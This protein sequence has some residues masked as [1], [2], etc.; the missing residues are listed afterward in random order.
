MFTGKLALRYI[1]TQKRHSALTVCS[2]ALAIAILTVIFTA[3]TTYMGCMYEVTYKKTPYHYTFSYYIV[4]GDTQKSEKID[5]FI[6]KFKEYGT[7]EKEENEVIVSFE[8]RISGSVYC[9]FE[10]TFP[11][12][13]GKTAVETIRDLLGEVGLQVKMHGASISDDDVGYI[14]SSSL[15]NYRPVDDNDRVQ[16]VLWIILLYV[17]II[18]IILVLR[19][20]ID[21]AFEISSKERERQFGV[22]QSV[23]ATPMQIVRIITFEGLIL[24]VAGLPLGILAGI[25]IAFAVFKIIVNECIIGVFFTA[26]QASELIKLHVNPLLTFLAAATGILWVLLSAYGVGMRVIKKTPI[27][28]MSARSNA[29]K[30]VKKR[31]LFGKIFGWTGTLAARNNRRQPKRFIVSVLSLTV[32]ITL[33]ASVT[34]IV[35]KFENS[36]T[37]PLEEQA[38]LAEFNFGV[39]YYYKPTSGNTAYEDVCKRFEES[40]M[41]KEPLAYIANTDYNIISQNPGEDPSRYIILFLNK[42]LYMKLFNNNPP[43]SYEELS[44]NRSYIMKDCYYLNAE[45]GKITYTRQD[46]L[47]TLDKENILPEYVDKFQKGDPSLYFGDSYGEST[48]EPEVAED[49][50]EDSED[51]MYSYIYRGTTEKTL[52]IAATYT[53]G[54]NDSFRHS[55]G[56]LVLPGFDM[57][58]FISTVDAYYSGEYQYDYD[59]VMFGGNMLSDTFVDL[60]DPTNYDKAEDFLNKNGDLFT[61]YNDSFRSYRETNSMLSAIRIGSNA[62]NIL[63]ALIAIVNMVNILSTGILN[64]RGEIASLISVG[65]TDKQM[66]RMTVIECLQYVFISGI[67]SI[68]LCE[69]LMALTQMMIGKDDMVAGMFG[70]FISYAAPIPK[71]LIA[72]VPAFIAALLASF[73]PLYGLRKQSI[74]EQI[75][76]ID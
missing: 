16:W 18:F 72:L 41:F 26:E 65:M 59:H 33:F 43:V 46:R 76:T 21:T 38:P 60:I 2:I 15:G 73:I 47:A 4:E 8:K 1:K 28:A 5:A 32:S 67:A 50:E 27:Q 69:V 35:D 68:I 64:R 39:S 20:L 24:S 7:A 22:L 70:Q 51:R 55:Y 23:G 57:W 54:T 36:L 19:L 9:F 10:K 53:L 62:L 3:F 45:N 66:N 75:R 49:D 30:K 52:D 13:S 42:P 48:E 25:G 61:W 12:N 29:V 74:V 6:E 40:G 11:I 34:I 14:G 44:E 37:G 58:D 17:V 71:V 63:F 31:S 56:N